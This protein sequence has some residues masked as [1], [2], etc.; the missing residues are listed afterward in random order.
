MRS[1]ALII[2]IAITTGGCLDD[3]PPAPASPFEGSAMA[4]VESLVVPATGLVASRPGECFTTVYKNSLAAMA[5]LHQGN[6]AAATRIFDHFDTYLANQSSPFRG[7]PQDWDPCTGQPLNDNRWEGDN[8]FLLMALNYYSLTTGQSDRYDNLTIELVAWLS[9]R[10]NGCNT[11][12]AEGTANMYAAL[13]PHVANPDAAMALER[14][15]TC[16]TNNVVYYLV[17]D[18]TVR[19][20]LVFDRYAGFDYLANFPVTENWTVNGEPIDALKAFSADTF[21]N[22]EISAQLLLAARLT[23]REHLVPGLRKELEKLWIYSN[24][25]KEAGLPYFLTNI[26]FSQSAELGIIDPTVYML[27]VYWNFNPFRPDTLM[28]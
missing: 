23:D 27:F 16:F 22:V 25:G 19:G 7:F 11:I 4:F 21:A 20:A 13:L 26:G 18:H 8:A 2:L 17:L 24:S 10:S 12:V 15:N 14:L 6:H 9:H 5:F 28:P 3:Y 1:L